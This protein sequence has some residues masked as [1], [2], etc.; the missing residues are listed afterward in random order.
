MKQQI[1][2]NVFLLMLV[3]LLI[4]VLTYTSKSSM[5]A[6][7]QQHGLFETAI[8]DVKH[9]RIER[10]GQP[11]M[12]LV[13]NK[14]WLL[15]KP[16]LAPLNHERVRHLLT[17]VNEPI[18]HQLTRKKGDLKTFKLDAERIKLTLNDEKITFGMTNPVTHN[19]YVLKNA[20]IYTIKEIVYGTLGS[21]VTH[22]LQHHLLPK[23]MRV[24]QIEAPAIFYQT[25]KAKNSWNALEATNIADYS[26]DE[27]ILGIVS[28][29]IQNSESNN[30]K[31]NKTLTLTTLVFDI[32]AITPTLILG[33]A[34]LQVKY[35]IDKM[36]TKHVL[37]VE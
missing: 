28:L 9:I 17:I 18:Q 4:G 23:S 15:I 30:E 14:Q 22:L 7:D 27:T 26:A 37:A 11:A 25:K 20:D 2:L 3:A 6:A 5:N 34:D 32:L 35:T 36:A 33:R 13:K 31:N 29:T 19:R 8:Q 21:S 12:V 16:A 1:W 10:Q 24:T